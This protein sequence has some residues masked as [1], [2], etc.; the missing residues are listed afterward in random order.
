MRYKKTFVSLLNT[1]PQKLLITYEAYMIT[2]LS[3]NEISF[4]DGGMCKKTLLSTASAACNTVGAALQTF[5]QVLHATVPNLA[6]SATKWNSQAIAGL[7]I[8][9]LGLSL[10]CAAVI[11]SSFSSAEQ[12]C[13]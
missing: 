2:N 12:T 7:V 13:P 10:N 3:L 1:Y 6:D 8:G 11:L 9:V 4:V 5:G